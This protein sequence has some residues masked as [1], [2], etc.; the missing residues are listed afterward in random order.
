LLNG[1]A[2]QKHRQSKESCYR[3]LLENRIGG[4]IMRSIFAFTTAL[5][6]ALPTIAN[7]T[8]GTHGGPG[9]RDLATGKCLSWAEF[10]YRCGLDGARCRPEKLSPLVKELQQPGADPHKLMEQ[11]H[12]LSQ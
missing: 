3:L 6:V 2:T 9:Y 8:C 5:M 11:S 4:E 7:A 1:I 10:S 12:R